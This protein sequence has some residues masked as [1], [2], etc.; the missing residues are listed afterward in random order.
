MNVS[1]M[2]QSVIYQ[3]IPTSKNAHVCATDRRGILDF[4]ENFPEQLFGVQYLEVLVQ[5]ASAMTDQTGQLQHG[6]QKHS[7]GMES[8]MSNVN[9]RFDN[10]IT[11]IKLNHQEIPET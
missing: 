4:V 2:Y 10:A 8:F 7:S 3:L 9:S 6:F 5:H 11:S 1:T